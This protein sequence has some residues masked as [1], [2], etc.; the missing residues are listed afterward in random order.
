MRNILAFISTLLILLIVTFYTATSYGASYWSRTYFVPIETHLSSIMQ[1]LDGGYLVRGWN[2]LTHTHSFLLKLN[3][4]GVKSWGKDLS[5]GSLVTQTSDGGYIM[6][7]EYFW[8][9]GSDFSVQKLDENGNVSW[10][11]KYGIVQEYGVFSYGRAVHQTADGGYI[12][13]GYTNAFGAGDYDMWVLKLDSTGDVLW[14]KTYGGGS[15][16]IKQ[17]SDNGYIMAG[18]TS[19][20]GAGNKDAWVLK[21]DAD[22]TIIWQKTY[23]GI[24]DDSFRVIQQIIDG[25]Y[26]IT[27][28]SNS[29]GT[30]DNQA[31]E[32][33][34][35]T[36][37]NIVWE[38]TYGASQ[39]FIS[40]Q[41]TSDGSFLMGS[42]TI[43]FFISFEVP[44]IGIMKLDSNGEIPDCF[45]IT[46]T[47]S[48]SLSTDCNVSVMNTNV[49]AQPTFTPTIVVEEP[50]A[51]DIPY[52]S[53]TICCVD[54]DDHDS[55]GLGDICD[56]CPYH[57]NPLQEDTGD[58]ED[59]V[60]DICDN[61]PDTYNPNQEDT[62]P[63]QGN[64]I[65][66][67]CDCE[68][69]FDCDGDVD[70]TDV[71]TFLVD[72]GRFQLNNPCANGNPCNGD[73]ICDADVDSDDV[74]MFLEDFG[75]STF[76][77][78]CPPCV[79]GSW[80]VYP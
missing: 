11:K 61:C 54:S 76:N 30:G 38:K 46:I 31:W 7:G 45:A 26:T 4:N 16:S 49:I 42:D 44:C 20:F 37:G 59:G 62:Y 52:L 71:E 66:D 67:A 5:Y 70:A 1:T 77:N 10:T 72:F 6:A 64:G 27:G 18:D 2:R 65:G 50:G 36:D 58:G 17:T 29:L 19:S 12:V 39:S 22:G 3:S 41:R 8:L 78:P 74:T 9:E 33:I 63:P 14:Q 55:D 21:L 13:A 32:I 57:S 51:G 25:G 79:T 56:N 28:F 34:L 24:N 47:T 53:N 80:C 60:G 73:T 68:C 15:V 23:G 40:I 69:D 75:R 35:D 48:N 43:D